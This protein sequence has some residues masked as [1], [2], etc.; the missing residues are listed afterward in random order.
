MGRS[1]TGAPGALGARAGRIATGVAAACAGAAVRIK[2]R[3]RGSGVGAAA[4]GSIAGLATA[5]I[6][7]AVAVSEA[8]SAGA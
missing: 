5:A 3:R 7:D 4:S 8:R 6:D 2:S 1:A